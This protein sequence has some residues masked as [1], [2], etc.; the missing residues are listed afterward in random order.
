MIVPF[1]VNVHAVGVPLTV[2]FVK[3]IFAV[4]DV[5]LVV[6]QFHATSHMLG[7]AI[8]HVTPAHCP[9]VHHVLCDHGHDNPS[10]YVNVDVCVP[11][12]HPA[13]TVLLENAGAVLSN[14]IGFDVAF[15][16]LQFHNL[17]HMFVHTTVH[18]AVADSTLIVHVVVLHPFIHANASVYVNV[19]A[20]F[21]L[22]QFVPYVLCDNN[23]GAVASYVYHVLVHVPTLL[24]M[25]YARKF[26]VIFAAGVILFA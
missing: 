15:V 23:V 22:Y 17:S 25:S 8:V 18:V 2:G 4:F 26:I 16:V 3:S 13:N 7:F 20:W 9:I 6:L 5:I 19:D 11:V 21:P 14:L 1:D 12:Y 10:V 24:Y